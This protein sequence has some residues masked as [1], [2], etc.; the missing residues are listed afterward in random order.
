[1]FFYAQMCK[2]LKNGSVFLEYLALP[3]ELCSCYGI[4]LG[5]FVRTGEAPG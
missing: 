4:F 5:R 2:D 1:M 3:E